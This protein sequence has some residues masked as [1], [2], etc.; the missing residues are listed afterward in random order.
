MIDTVAELK[1]QIHPNVLALIEDQITLDVV[2]GH[3]RK[4]S[5][6]YYGDVFYRVVAVISLR[7]STKFPSR[8]HPESW[9]G[10]WSIREITVKDDC[11]SLGWDLATHLV[12]S[13]PVLEDNT[14]WTA[15]GTDYAESCSKSSC[16]P[17]KVLPIA[18]TAKRLQ[19]WYK[20]MG[21]HIISKYSVD[22]LIK[23]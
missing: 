17:Q 13:M 15:K 12:V 6:T 1:S 23:S 11:W 22:H 21:G 3:M 20:L 14:Q 9:A 8:W 18:V 7:D 16:K 5:I 2:P 10:A 19:K 4:S